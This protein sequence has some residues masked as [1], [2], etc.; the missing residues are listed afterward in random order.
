MELLDLLAALQALRDQGTTAA[1]A[2]HLRLT[3]SAVSKRIAVL[4]ARV[5]A[6]LTEAQG[7]RLRLTP[8]GERLLVEAEPLL[9]QLQA[10]LAA[11]AP[12]GAL[13]LAAAESLL[14][15]GLPRVL[16][17]AADA[18]P[19]LILEL[20]AH[21][22]VGV[23]ER[24]RSGAA[25]LGLVGGL[26]TAPEL[27]VELLWEEEMVLVGPPPGAG[28]VPVYTV[29]ERSLTWPAIARA[30][31]HHA[32]QIEVVGRLESSAA[33]VGLARAG[34]ATAL[35]PAGLAQAFGG[36]PTAGVGIWPLP[37]VRRPVCLLSK[38]SRG[39]AARAFVEALRG[40]LATPLGRAAP[41]V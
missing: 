23:A 28:R 31:A 9:R 13:S 11:E 18:V 20:H 8:R 36:A 17:Q 6:P 16:R 29:E 30:L 5:G 4:E 39:R 2:V 41:L 40:A 26:V 35:V 37:G 21:R 22:G 24:V 7:R 38:G 27:D 25:A 34:F 32:P 19:G 12:A 14:A 3:Q 10:L 1:A 15:S 33:L